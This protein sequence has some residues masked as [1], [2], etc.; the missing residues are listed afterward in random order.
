MEQ[1]QIENNILIVRKSQKKDIIINQG[2]EKLTNNKI[3]TLEELFRNYQLNYDNKAI[4]YLMKKYSYPLDVSRI[5]LS[6]IIKINID[7]SNNLKINKLIELKKELIDNKLLTYN[8]TF[9]EYLKG[10]N[11]TLYQLDNLSKEEELLIKEISKYNNITTYR[12]E[13]TTYKHKEIIT[14]FSDVDEINYIATQITKLIKEGI[15]INKIKLYASNEYE[16]AIKRIFTWYHIPIILKEDNLYIAE[17]GQTFLK[18]LT[19]NREESLKKIEELYPLTINKNREIYNQIINILNNYTWCDSKEYLY[20][21]LEEEFK[22]TI[23]NQKKTKNAVTIIDS[24]SNSSTD[25]YIFLVGFNEG[26]IPNIYKDEDYLSDKEKELLDQE[27]SIEKNKRTQE[28]WIKDI[29]TTKNL[30]ITMK[31]NNQNGECYLSSLNDTLNL[32]QIPVPKEFNHSNIYNKLELSKKLDTLIKYNE[33]EEDTELLYNHYID[34]NYR[35]FNNTYTEIPKEII[36]DYLNN[37]LTLS[38]SSMNTYYQ[39]AYRYYLSNILKINIYEETFYTIIG[40]LYHHI[41]SLA[42]KKDIDIKEE[43]QKYIEKQSYTFDAKELFF[44]EKLE[45]ELEQIIEIIKKQNEENNLDNIHTEEKIEIPSKIDNMNI[46]FKGYIDKLICNDEENKIAIIDYKTGNPDLNL[47]NIIY[48]LDLQLPVYVY[49]ALYKYKDARIIGFYLQK[50]LNTEIKKDRKHSYK[51]LKE[52]QLK[53]QGYSNSDLSLLKEFDPNY[54]NSKIIKGMRTSAKGLS[55]KKVFD[56]VKIEKLKELTET[57]IKEASE[58][59][60]KGEF[61]IN[62]KRIGMNNVGCNY[63]NFKSICF[64][65]E[66]DIV[67]LKEYKEMEFLGGEEQ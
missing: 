54:D 5:Y 49:L 40:N 1:L 19:D 3:I 11:I 38:Y 7:E 30:T 23:I 9:I 64:M 25:D 43:Y 47:N 52:E 46:I 61:P 14:C 15:D 37:N 16:A 32:D 63:C 60:I 18:N 41:L 39:C 33:L 66:S 6:N 24:L 53:L 44:L 55:S 51:E 21:F 17:I 50:I 10:K 36:N 28:K 42:L 34:I 57:K 12:E 35:T 67:N 48:G 31:K 45:K 13:R 56:D 65:K 27:T 59:I 20:Y 8:K 22:K 26:E 2:K 58:K 29:I 62:P 4:Y